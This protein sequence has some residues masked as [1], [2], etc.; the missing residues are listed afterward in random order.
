[1]TTVER[2]GI[3]ALVVAI[4]L[5]SFG[6]GVCALA[7]VG[8]SSRPVAAGADGMAMRHIVADDRDTIAWLGSTRTTIAGTGLNPAGDSHLATVIASVHALAD[9]VAPEANASAEVQPGAPLA[10]RDLEMAWLAR[11][12][13]VLAVAWVV[14]G[15]LAA[16][17]RLVRRPGAAAAR[18]AWLAS[19]RPW[20]ARESTLG[21]LALDRWLLLIVPVALLVATRAVQTS[22][23][24]WVHL[25]VVIGAWGVFALV[26]RLVVWKHS[27]WPVIAAVG[28]V[29]VLR[30]IVTLI[31]LSLSGPGGSSPGLWES[32]PWRIVF[33][34][35]AIALFV[36]VFVAAGWALAAQIGARR[37]TGGVL[38]AVGA[39]LAVP[40]FV[41]ALVGT[42][43]MLIAWT[44]QLESLPW[45][46][47]R[48]ADATAPLQIPDAAAWWAAGLGLVIALVGAALALPARGR[49]TST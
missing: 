6:L 47:G 42:G 19:T 10:S 36:W 41:I 35:V 9:L 4:A 16:R 40:A 37:A 29:V 33:V 28:G 14:I 22:F 20:R 15:M 27:P 3:L 24:G 48:M 13:L 7:S 39:G 45:G 32:V 49:V 17:T 46:L 11:V 43:R 2:R 25:S 44:G 23:F 12:L 18:A 31:G 34:T 21:M 1:M 26:V 8:S 5:L 30:C 38:A